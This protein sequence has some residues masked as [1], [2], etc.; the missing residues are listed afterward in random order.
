MTD[1]NDKAG[2]ILG[3][4]LGTGMD[5][6]EI[7]D[8]LELPSV[9]TFKVIGEATQ[10]FEAELRAQVEHKLG[11]AL[12]A[13]ECAVRKSGEGKYLSV[14]FMLNMNTLEE[15]YEMYALL[16]ANPGTRFLL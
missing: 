11:R 5:K 8:L 6:K 13:Q 14:T 7:K 9:Y 15:I 2:P 12:E 16:K 1:K 3:W 10:T 4:S